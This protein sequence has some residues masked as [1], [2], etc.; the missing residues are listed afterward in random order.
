MIAVYATTAD[1]PQARDTLGQLKQLYESIVSSTSMIDTDR[2]ILMNELTSL[3]LE[4]RIADW[5]GD[6]AMPVTRFS[7]DLA[8][9]FVEAVP[10][11]MPMPGVS[12]CSDGS[13]EFDW[14]PSRGRAIGVGIHNSNRL[15]IAWLNGSDRGHGVLEFKGEVLPKELIQLI[16]SVHGSVHA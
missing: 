16:R 10:K 12:T 2:T 6:E 13:I 4:R 11:G 7:F 9:K 15:S 8:R 14:M 5:D 1:S 3:Y